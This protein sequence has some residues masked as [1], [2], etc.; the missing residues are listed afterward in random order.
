[1]GVA[2]ITI[3]HPEGLSALP[4]PAQNSLWDLKRI[5]EPFFLNNPGG[6]PS[7]LQDVL[8]DCRVEIVDHEIRFYTLDVL[9]MV[10]TDA[11]EVG[12]GTA[13]PNTGTLSHLF[14]DNAQAGSIPHLLLE[15][16]GAGDAA[17]AF[18]ISGIRF[19]QFGIDQSDNNRIKFGKAQ[20]ATWADT[21]LALD[22]TTNNLILNDGPEVI[23]GSGSPEGVETA[24]EGSIYHNTDGG[25]GT[26]TYEKVAGTGNTGWVPI[27]LR[28]EDINV[29]DFDTTSAQPSK[30]NVTDQ[31]E[32]WSFPNSGAN[33]QLFHS[34]PIAADVPDGNVIFT[35]NVASSGTSGGDWLVHIRWLIF[36]DGDDLASGGTAVI[37]SDVTIAAPSVADELQV[38]L[39]STIS[40]TPPANPAQSTLMFS[41]MA[42][43]GADTNTDAMRFLGMKILFVPS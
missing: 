5:L 17:L 14:K 11:G 15:Q 19:W 6:F 18:L 20:S 29:N 16:A 27:G 35:L 7:K 2:P 30:I 26:T 3:W 36:A 23:T 42:T 21:L 4:Q 37:D 8:Q 28:P 33:N 12:I 43:A 22:P 1:M 9:R 25:L 24:P 10:I 41:R 34:S 40:F 13:T 39:S 38:A 31:Y 32:A